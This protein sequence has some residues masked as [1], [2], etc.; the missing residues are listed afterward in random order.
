[1]VSGVSH[2]MHNIYWV[3][4][5]ILRTLGQTIERS[6]FYLKFGKFKAE[7]EVKISNRVE[8]FKTTRARSLELDLEN[9]I[10]IMA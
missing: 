3:F 8:R 2:A 9:L 6:L 10:I 4:Y 5:V 7:P 1:M